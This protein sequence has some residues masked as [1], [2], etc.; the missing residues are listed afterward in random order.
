VSVFKDIEIEWKGESYKVRP[1]MQLI[2]DLESVQGSSL[3][4]FASRASQNDAPVSVAYE[5][6]A[7]T[8]RHAGVKDV[9][10]EKIFEDVGGVRVEVITMALNI[11]MACLN[12]EDDTKKKPVE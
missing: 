6:V 1:S 12:L 8:L 4:V 5:Y 3:T 9:T 10:A 11:V 2:F 7:K